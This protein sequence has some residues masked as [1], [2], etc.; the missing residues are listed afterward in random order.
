MSKSALYMTNTTPTPVA[1]GGLLQ[2]GTITR[3]M[4]TAI[5]ADGDAITLLEP[6]Y[7]AVSVNATVQPDAAAAITLTVRE[8]EAPIPGA[9][10][11]ATPAT[12]ADDTPLQIPGAI[13]RVFCRSTKTLTF[14]LSAAATVA[15]AAIT[16]AKV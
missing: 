6:G 5:R 7:Y 16:V 12:I 10:V 3:R 15:N 1:A 4:G 11:T 2:I 13:V 8:N 14:V 9:T